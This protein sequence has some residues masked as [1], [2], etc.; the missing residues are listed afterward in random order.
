MTSARSSRSTP[1]E[2]TLRELQT[3]VPDDAALGLAEILNEIV[4]NVR[5][6]IV[7][8]SR[9]EEILRNG[10][11]LQSKDD[12][13]NQAPEDLTKDLIIDEL[14]EYFE[15]PYGTQEV[16]TPAEN[17]DQ[18]VDYSVSLENYSNIDSKQLLI[19]AEPINKRL[20][21][22][23]HGIGQV[24]GWLHH[25][26]F[27]T[28][29]GIATDGL[30]WVLLKKDPDT[31]TIN[32]IEYID[33]Q[34]IFLALF[35]NL[36]GSKRSVEEVLDEENIETLE[37]F[38]RAFYFDNFISVASGVQSIIRKKKKEITESFYDE[39]IEI[40]F[41]I[42]D[43]N[44]EGRDTER[45]L[46]GDGIE[47]P[48]GADQEDRRLFAVQLMNRLVFIKFLED[49][50][51]VDESLLSEVKE[52]HESGDHLGDFYS[53]F[54]QPLIYDVFN[55]PKKKRPDKIQERDKYQNIPYLNGGLFRANLEDE[56]EYRV[57]DSVLLDVVDLLENYQFS[58]TGGPDELDPSVL[59]TVFEKTINYLAGEEGEQKDLG[60]YYTPDNITRFCADKA[61]KES[62]LNDFKQVLSKEWNWREGEL[63]HYNEVYELLDALSPNQDVVESLLDVVDD[64]HVVDPSC[65]SGHFLTSSL[66]EIVSIRRTLYEKHEDSP[67]PHALK[68]QTV[69]E[70]LYGVDIVGPGVEITKLRLWLSIMSEL[71][72]SD[73]DNLEPGELALPNVAFNIREGNSLVGYTDVQRLKLDEEDNGHQ[74]SRVD[75][76]GKDSVEEL[77]KKRQ[78]QIDR[79]KRLYGED[80][81]EI[82]EDIR[83]K[84]T[85]Y[86]KR[87]NMKLLEDLRDADVAFEL[88]QDE[89]AAPSLPNTALHK[90]SIRFDNPINKSEK[91]AL[92]DKYRDQK[93]M[94]INNG[95]GGYVSMTLDHQYINKSPD[96]RLENIIE[97]L[98][99]NI[100]DLDV[101]RYLTL[102]DLEEMEFLHWP[103]EFY[104]VFDQGGFDVALGNPPYGI[105][106]SEAESALGTYPDENHS[107]MV[108]TTRAEDLIH[109]T[110]QI[111]YVVPKLVTYGYQW[112]DARESLL[113]RDLEYLVDLQEAF[114][115]VKGEQ[116]IMMLRKGDKPDDNVII[117]RLEDN[118]FI[119]K[120]YSQSKLT[121]DCFYM[122][123]DEK[124]QSLIEKLQSYPSIDEAGYA[125]ATK[126]I[127]YFDGYRTHT[128]E[129]LL[130]I[131][132]DNI[133]QFRIVGET[134]FGESI[135][136][137][138]DVDPDDFEQEKLVWQDIL[139][140]IKNPEPRVI[141]QAAVDY[142]GAY[143]ADTAIYATSEENSLEYLCGLMNSS[144]FSW[145]TY[146]LIHNRAIRTMHFTPIYFGRLPTPPEDDDE[147]IAKIESRT[148][149]IMEMGK[150]DENKLMEKYRELNEAVYDLYKL[151]EEERELVDSEAPPHKKTLVNWG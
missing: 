119:L 145:F 2:F 68:K 101:Y 63:E 8:D 124:N 149:E 56:K 72:N 104:E 24:K 102:E 48:R 125:N 52:V 110:G 14:L 62:L 36:A 148:E 133:G 67:S 37:R 45:C 84:D 139:A 100:G 106:I 30:K 82:E 98:E 99:D 73:I 87:L 9:L 115:G 92:D 57:I 5:Q 12:S 13:R 21:Q 46:V 18:W 1:T 25:E 128:N 16:N 10:K 59:G 107:S 83:E 117:G 34:K 105:S 17:E 95:N 43:E 140:H 97:H 147:L 135:T 93:G 28:D 79:Y 6:R 64:F 7:S 74:Q 11:I 142:K 118:K 44:S 26:P 86:N 96:G 103:L 71:T 3:S 41:G 42:I 94:R 121:S 49:T 15:Y 116:I 134:R 4:G 123:V 32:Q 76:W 146:N 35:E 141:L 50:E 136:D 51:I 69:L 88:E 22:Q 54:I 114:E 53:T 29:F 85:E 70:N 38:Y 113:E 47:V 150:G 122:W 127:D 132:G 120:N 20:N 144:L 33:L 60:A 23:K 91:E 66:N 130:G 75:D 108:F 137:R 65:G 151:G 112:T 58:A 27:E 126:G 31:H 78:K 81:H 40:V 89:I 143:I 90:V 77:I 129:G 131:R 80:A 138:S 55:N 19:E 111:S 61:V 109:K 39:Y